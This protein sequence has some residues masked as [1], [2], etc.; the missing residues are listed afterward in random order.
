[1]SEK[2]ALITGAAG[3]AGSTLI[4]YILE[5]NPE[6]RII[7]C[8][9]R[10]SNIDNI[11][12]LQEPDIAGKRVVFEQLNLEDAHEVGRS[13][14]FYQ[15]DKLFA[16][17]AQSYVPQ[18]WKS[19][20]ETI[21]TNIIGAVNILE[22]VRRYAKDCVV[23]LAGSSEEYG[24]VYP[25][26]T[27]I[28]ETNPLRPLSP[29]GMTKVAQENLGYIYNKSY[30][31]KTILTRGFNHEGPRRG[32]EFVTSQICKQAAEIVCGKREKF[33]LGNLEAKRDYTD[34]RDM[35]R[36]YW[37]LTEKGEF[38]TPYNICSENCYA[39]KGLVHSVA[40][41]AHISEEVVQDLNRMRPADVEIL[42]GDC[43]KLKK[44]I[45]WKPEYDFIN[46][47]LVGMFESWM[48]KLTNEPTTKFFIEKE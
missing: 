44:Q 24:M 46:D 31:V 5:N 16:L 1:M 37:L 28:K 45:D 18:S 26:E 39:I 14:E 20:A 12:H 3:M 29:Y 36:A 22:A 2:V 40:K 34:V 19:P 41:I 23:Q 21:E 17:G 15:P 47:T 35:V 38:G 11:K 48:F 13:I 32:E 27:P 33:C 6:Y 4:D 43:S 9:R 10:H 8:I 25:E 42:Y 30:G 7:A